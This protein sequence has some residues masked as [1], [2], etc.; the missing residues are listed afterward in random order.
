MFCTSSYVEMSPTHLIQ[1][2]RWLELLLHD[3]IASITLSPA[4][5]THYHIFSPA[6]ITTHWVLHILP[7]SVLHPLPRIESCTYYHI[8]S[9]TQYN[10]YIQSWSCYHIHSCIIYLGLLPPHF[11]NQ[12]LH[13]PLSRSSSTDGLQLARGSRLLLQ[14]CLSNKHH[15][16]STEFSQFY[17]VHQWAAVWSTVF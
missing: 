7:H 16:N 15:A 6:P 5:C 11:L 1:L 3:S 8:Q 4:P 9:C 14:R 2:Q 10:Y 17:E 13:C 12:D